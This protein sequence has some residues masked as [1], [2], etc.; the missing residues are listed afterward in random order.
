MKIIVAA[1][2]LFNELRSAEVR[3]QDIAKKNGISLSSFNYHYATK[4]DLD[5]A[6]FD[7]MM[8][9][10]IQNLYGNKTFI[11]EGEG[12]ASTE[13]FFVFQKGMESY[14]SLIYPYLTEKVVNANKK[15]LEQQKEKRTKK[16]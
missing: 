14:F 9:K 6:I 3:F 15:Y 5:K 11:M 1:L 2:E 8:E 4:K 7:Y 13:S 16:N 10:L 12:S